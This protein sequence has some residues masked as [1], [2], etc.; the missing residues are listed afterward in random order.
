MTRAEA[1]VAVHLPTAPGR[2][3]PTLPA[4]AFVRPLR[5]HQVVGFLPYWEVGGFTP[6][7]RDL[8]TLAYWAVGLGTG[9]SIAQSGEGYSTLTST[10]LALD[11]SQ[12]HAAGDRVLLTVFSQ[13]PSVLHSVAAHPSTAGPR[14]ARNVAA[15]LSAGGFDGVDL[16][17][18]GNSTADRDGF[19]RFVAS[20]S[21]TLRS[22]GPDLVDH[23]GHL[24]DLCLGP[25]GLLR[26]QSAHRICKRALR[27]GLRHAAARCRFGYGAIDE[28][29]L[30]RRHHARRVRLSGARAADRA[31]H[32]ALRLRLPGHESIRRSY[33]H[34]TTARCHLRGHRGCRSPA[35]MGPGDRNSMDS[36]QERRE[37]AP[38]LVRR[39]GLDRP[40][41]RARRPVPL[42][43]RRH[44]GAGDVGQRRVHN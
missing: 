8:T 36:V 18:E 23:V 35:A 12:A 32:S 1:A 38:D 19:V 27:D 25:V 28:R 6:D 20:F 30:E 44:L 16:D 7:Y 31:R 22:L 41:V 10:S 17:L 11:M 29:P 42:R 3:A 5:A 21:R 33:D 13:N 26:R 24:S 2:P 14:L 39:P 4:G 9:G 37:V 43:R 15:L 40:Q 34:G